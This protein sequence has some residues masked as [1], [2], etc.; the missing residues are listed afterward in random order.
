[1][2]LICPSCTAAYDVPDDRLGT[3]PRR[4]RCT[5]CT[6]QWTLQ[7]APAPLPPAPAPLIAEARLTPAV[8]FPDYEE[9]QPGW[10]RR[11]LAA[12]AAS[13][14]VLVGLVAAAVQFRAE[15]MRGWPPSQRVY[16]VLGYAVPG[17][18]PR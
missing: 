11:A 2:R 6:H 12:W 16:A 1:M 7:P 8:S 13:I 18:E 10:D 15:V 5:R 4:L 9:E 3:G 17:A 14:V